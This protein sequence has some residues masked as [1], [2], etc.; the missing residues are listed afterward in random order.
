M[1][2][3]NVEVVRRVYAEWELGNSRAGV[4]AQLGQSLAHVGLDPFGP[5]D[6][7]PLARIWH[8]G[9]VEAPIFSIWTFRGRKVVRF[10][11]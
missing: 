10:D 6:N 7:A 3:E 9:A 8:E 4:A 5:V 1:S 11:L 2:E